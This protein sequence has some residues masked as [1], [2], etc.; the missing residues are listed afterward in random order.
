MLSSLIIRYPGWV[1][2][3]TFMHKYGLVDITPV[4]DIVGKTYLSLLAGA[5]NVE[6]DQV[7]TFVKENH[8]GHPYDALKFLNAFDPSNVVQDDLDEPTML[9][10]F[11]SLMNQHMQYKENERDMIPMIHRIEATHKETGEKVVDVSKAIFYGNEKGSAMENSVSLPVAVVADLVL[12]G[13]F[14]QSGV[15]ILNISELY[16]PILEYLN[17]QGY[18]YEVTQDKV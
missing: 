18:S 17:T 13:K 11:S 10:A 16:E 1:D 8:P 12:S 5:F 15:H 4:T 7:E 9:D 6:E 3:I 2:I 14:L